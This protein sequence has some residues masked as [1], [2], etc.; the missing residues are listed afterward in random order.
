MWH[1]VQA[2]MHA[3]FGGK[4]AAECL[5][6]CLGILIFFAALA[7]SA[8]LIARFFNIEFSDCRLVGFLIFVV[9]MAMMYVTR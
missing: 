7:G 1:A 4:G 8:V 3:L 6:V 5:L 9:A 2:L